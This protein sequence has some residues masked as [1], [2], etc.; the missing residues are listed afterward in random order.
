VA[1]GFLIVSLIHVVSQRIMQVSGTAAIVNC[2]MNKLR[3]PSAAKSVSDI[4]C[5]VELLDVAS[6]DEKR[7]QA[8]LRC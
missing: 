2:G 5:R 3:P 4:R 8:H 6:V 1:H 7:V